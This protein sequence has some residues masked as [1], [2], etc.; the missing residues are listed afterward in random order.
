MSAN[1]VRFDFFFSEVG[2]RRTLI[3]I[4][5]ILR[6]KPGTESILKAAFLNVAAFVRDHEPE[7][8]SFFMTSSIA[9]PHVFTTYERFTTRAAMETHNRAAVV[10]EL[11]AIAA[12]ILEAPTVLEIGEEFFAK[13]SGSWRRDGM[14]EASD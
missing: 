12:P 13:N 7:A 2:E 8:V 3:T 4:T 11:H 5:A 9:A 1:A 6:V 14:T 10:K